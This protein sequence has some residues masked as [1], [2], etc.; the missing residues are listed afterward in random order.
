MLRQVLANNFGLSLLCPL[1]TTLVP[2]AGRRQTPVRRVHRGHS[3][4]S[5]WALTRRDTLIEVRTDLKAV[6][7]RQPGFPN[8]EKF[9][10]SP[11]WG[12]F[13][14]KRLKSKSN[15]QMTA[16]RAHL[17]NS[18]ALYRKSGVKACKRHNQAG[19][20]RRRPFRI[21]AT[22]AAL[23]VGQSAAMWDCPPA[24]D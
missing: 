19:T 4:E 10:K 24:K 9:K 17:Q 23:F 1:R 20:S 21:S 8:P 16:W 5:P 3:A 6:A 7:T 22:L 2:D 13:K 14:R 15:R 11:T 18:L 12:V